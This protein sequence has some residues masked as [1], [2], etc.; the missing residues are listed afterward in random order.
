M[1]DM[2]KRK[3]QYRVMF[4]DVYNWLL[5][6]CEI[7]NKDEK[8]FIATAKE[9][10]KLSENGYDPLRNAL[11]MAVYSEMDRLAQEAKQP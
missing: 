3:T 2:E 11:L 5:A 6:T 7:S 8:F 1:V 9:M 10:V 4:R